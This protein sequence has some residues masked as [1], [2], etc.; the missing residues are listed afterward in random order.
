VTTKVEDLED[1][2]TDTSDP[3]VVLQE[4][5]TAEQAQK[6]AQL[7][8]QNMAASVGVDDLDPDNINIATS[9]QEASRMQ[10]GDMETFGESG[11]TSEGEFKARAQPK[12]GEA[13]R[14][15]EFETGV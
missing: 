12:V 3:S 15:V 11:E 13:M 8:Q 14:G 10:E 1:D 9:E 6:D 5:K 2:P 7:R 4:L